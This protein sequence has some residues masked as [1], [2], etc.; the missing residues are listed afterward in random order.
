MTWRGQETVSFGK[1]VYRIINP[2]TGEI[3]EFPSLAALVDGYD[4]DAA[5]LGRIAA[6]LGPAIERRWQ[7]GDESLDLVAAIRRLVRT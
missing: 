4:E 5:L 2:V 1:P 3:R 6:A 7:D